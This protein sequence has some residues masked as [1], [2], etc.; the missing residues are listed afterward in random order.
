MSDD[1][2]CQRCKS[3]RVVRC[4]AK[5]SDM[6]WAAIGNHEYQGYVPTDMGIGNDS[7]DYVKFEYCLECGQL[8]NQW[9]VPETQLEAG[10]KEL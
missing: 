1:V 2:K 9:P 4:G 6:F 8:Q 5:C 10:E 7:W 3:Q